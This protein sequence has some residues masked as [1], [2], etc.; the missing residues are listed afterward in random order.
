MIDKELLAAEVAKK[1]FSLEVRVV[2][3]FGL[4]G[5]EAKQNFSVSDLP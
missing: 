4:A 1:G 5:F 3:V 2:E